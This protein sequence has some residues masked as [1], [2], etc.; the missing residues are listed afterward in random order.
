MSHY[1]GP[2]VE[3]TYIGASSI[4]FGG[5]EPDNPLFCFTLL[6]LVLHTAIL[7]IMVHCVEYVMHCGLRLV[8]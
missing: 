2:V 8:P 6:V 3:S 7:L 4:N 5:L 1:F